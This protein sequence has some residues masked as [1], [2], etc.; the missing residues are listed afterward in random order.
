MFDLERCI[1]SDIG[2][3]FVDGWEDPLYDI[4][5]DYIDDHDPLAR[6][7]QYACYESGEQLMH[8]N[9]AYSELIDLHNKIAKHCNMANYYFGVYLY[10]HDPSFDALQK[11]DILSLEKLQNTEAI[12]VLIR[13]AVS[14][15]TQAEDSELF[16][17]WHQSF[18]RNLEHTSAACLWLGYCS[19]QTIAQRTGQF[20][21]LYLCAMS[22][23]ERKEVVSDR[24]QAF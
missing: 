21:E 3:G 8:T 11:I 18:V 14:Q 1:N 13:Q 16:L 7:L 12:H 24:L 9:E 23:S 19:A 5:T 20:K 10:E 6:E 17:H 4:L 22:G 2:K 15:K